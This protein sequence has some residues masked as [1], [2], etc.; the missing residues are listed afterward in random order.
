MDKKD[1]IH[2]EIPQT[3]GVYFFKRG[4]E[5]IYIGKATSLRDRVKSYFMQNIMSTRGP[6]IQLMLIQADTIDWRICD[7]VLEALILESNLIKQY[8]PEFNTS[9]KD[10]KSYNYVVIT[11][12][13]FPRIFTVRERELKKKH[14][15]PFEIAKT[16]GPFPYGGSLVEALRIIR[17]IFPFRDRK[18]TDTMNER[19]YT[20][21]GLVPDTS[22]KEAQGMYMQTIQHIEL[23]FKGKKKELINVL[24]QKMNDCAQRLKF[25]EASIFK[26]QIFSLQHINDVSLLKREALTRDIEFRIEGY[27]VAHI[28]G[29]SPVGVMVVI[30][31]SEPAL[32]AY[33]KFKIRSPGGS[34]DLASLAE[35]LERRLGHNEW[36]L[37]KLIVVDG[38]ALHKRT[39]ERVLRDAG[40]E[41][42]VVAV[43]KTEK[44]MPRA[45]LGRSSFVAEHERGILLANHEAHRSAK[46]YHNTLEEK[47]MR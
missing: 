2:L 3:P 41:I 26:R 43:V 24:T 44:H 38:G 23:F 10:S 29:S 45:I 1:L 17:K 9:S 40:I 5:I 8:Q 46:N 14:E 31:D 4:N 37:P 18:S 20:Q 47:R 35:I 25:E 32:S 19:F 13:D 30:I 15:L 39:A 7:S 36:P 21:L 16:F 22:T 34:D 33:R 12:E 42:P 11:K 27:D 6:K 28:S